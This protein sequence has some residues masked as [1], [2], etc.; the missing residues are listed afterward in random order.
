M[1]RNPVLLLGAA[2]VA[3]QAAAA[4]GAPIVAPFDPNA[5][6]ILLR[7]HAPDARHW[8]GTDN[9]GR[10]TLARALWGYRTLFAAIA[11]RPASTEQQ[12]M[13]VEASD[14]AYLAQIRLEALRVPADHLVGMSDVPFFAPART[15]TFGAAA[16]PKKSRQA[17]M[18]DICAQ[19]PFIKAAAYIP[20]NPQRI[21]VKPE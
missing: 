3:V 14:G 2:L 7:L 1:T 10:D 9:F 12:F 13:R 17:G 8:L 20:A 15:M 6:E 5:Q 16:R 11:K 19:L 21:P 18:T 4:L